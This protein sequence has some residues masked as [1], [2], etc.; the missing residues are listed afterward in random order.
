[1][2]KFIFMNNIKYHSHI[3]LNTDINEKDILKEIKINF[4]ELN[5]YSIGPINSKF[6][7][8]VY[9]E[10]ITLR[11]DLNNYCNYLIKQKNTLTNYSYNYFIK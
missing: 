2:F 9:L 10:N 4:K 3:V 6:N 8:D 11:N 7:V 1:M 5:T